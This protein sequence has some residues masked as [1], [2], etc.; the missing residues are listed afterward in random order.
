MSDFGL[1]A[2]QITHRALT[3]EFRLVTEH[4]DTARGTVVLRATTDAINALVGGL[5]F[6]VE[7]E[8]AAND[9]MLSRQLERGAFGQAERAAERNRGLSV[10]YAEEVRTLLADTTRDIRSV[11]DRWTTEVPGL[12]RPGRPRPRPNW[13][14]ACSPSR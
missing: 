1:D 7:D 2:D 5:E 13:R 12:T 8:Q 9:L 14:P 4:E 10:R 6:D 11:A 3:L